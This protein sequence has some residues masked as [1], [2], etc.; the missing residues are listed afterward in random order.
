MYSRLKAN[1]ACVW[2]YYYLNLYTE[3]KIEHERYNMNINVIQKEEEEKGENLL[4][5]II[6][7]C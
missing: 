5:I 7:F 6:K 4:I 2:L 1:I 3:K